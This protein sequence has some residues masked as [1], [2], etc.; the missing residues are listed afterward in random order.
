MVILLIYKIWTHNTSSKSTKHF[1]MGRCNTQH[2][3]KHSKSSKKLTT[4]MTGKAAMPSVQV[5]LQHLGTWP[6][7][8]LRA[9][10]HHSQA[11]WLWASY[12]TS[13]PSFFTCKVRIKTP[14]S[15]SIKYHSAH[16]TLSTVPGTCETSIEVFSKDGVGYFLSIFLLS[17]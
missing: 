2:L 12:I 17:E 5:A 8:R 13:I 4:T 1:Y 9:C 11:G 15:L 16:K 14:T 6:S 7:R 10:P 3:Q